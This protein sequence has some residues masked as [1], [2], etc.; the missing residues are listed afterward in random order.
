MSSR[1]LV[2]KAIGIFGVFVLSSPLA[3]AAPP[4]GVA[5]APT[6]AAQ[7]TTHSSSMPDGE[8]DCRYKPL[9]GSRI[10]VHVCTSRD[11]AEYRMDRRVRTIAA[12]VPGS[13]SAPIAA[14]LPQVQ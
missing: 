6:V 12:V 14:P 4:A 8:Y 13:G 10:K 1:D 5:A 11:G 2:R 9:P 3:L 7:P